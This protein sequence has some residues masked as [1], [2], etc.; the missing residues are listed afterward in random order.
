MHSISMHNLL[1]HTISLSGLSPGS[2]MT[3]SEQ[4]Q[5]SALAVPVLVRL[6][7]P[8]HEAMPQALLIAVKTFLTDVAEA[9]EENRSAVVMAY[10]NLHE[11]NQLALVCND[12]HTLVDVYVNHHAV[13]AVYELFLEA[14]TSHRILLLQSQRRA[15]LPS[16]LRDLCAHFNDH[17]FA[18]L[19]AI[20][21]GMYRWRSNPNIRRAASGATRPQLQINYCGSGSGR[22][23]SIIGDWHFFWKPKYLAPGRNF[24]YLH[25]SAS[26]TTV[27]TLSSIPR[28]KQISL[29]KSRSMEVL[30]GD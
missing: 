14:A 30:D 29:R 4:F 25:R 28:I 3:V 24:L 19:A 11:V 21:K 22:L 17:V 6:K 23:T 2:T 26:A 16:R 15:K 20:A 13:H 7:P 27:R 10:F 8:A 12:W 1:V 9:H 18:K 5:R